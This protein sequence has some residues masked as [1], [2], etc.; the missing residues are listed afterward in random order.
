[1]IFDILFTVL[2]V[3]IFYVGLRKGLIKFLSGIVALVAGWYVA[4]TYQHKFLEIL[5]KYFGIIGK[6]SLYLERY[7][8]RANPSLGEGI[9]LEGLKLVI[10]NLPLPKGIGDTI[11]NKIGELSQGLNPLTIGGVLGRFFSLTL[12]SVASFILLFLLT[13]YLL[14]FTANLLTKLFK[15]LQP[16]GFFNHLLGGLL[17]LAFWILVIVFLV[18]VLESVLSYLLPASLFSNLQGSVLFGFLKWVSKTRVLDI[19]LGFFYTQFLKL[20]KVF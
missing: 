3:Y 4:F 12:L 8:Y 20:I 17:N 19:L 5:D 1:M 7:L 13:R 18:G 14:G 15:F 9:N 10:N 6:F 11:I 16:M 2:F